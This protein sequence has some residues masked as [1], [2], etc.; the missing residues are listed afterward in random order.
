MIIIYKTLYVL[1]V[2]HNN[3][4]TLTTNDK[5]NTKE[6]I[7]KIHLYYILFFFGHGQVPTTNTILSI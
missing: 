6:E 3:Y 4:Y 1:S 7:K 2:K 5:L